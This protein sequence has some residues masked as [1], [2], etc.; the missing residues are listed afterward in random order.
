MK[1]NSRRTGV[2]R[3]EKTDREKKQKKK[4]NPRCQTTGDGHSL[5]TD[6]GKTDSTG[7]REVG[8]DL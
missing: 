8:Y 6:P 7:E 2:K 1:S 5:I 3:K 4:K